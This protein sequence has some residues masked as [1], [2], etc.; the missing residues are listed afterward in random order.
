MARLWLKVK[1]KLLKVKIKIVFDKKSRSKETR[2]AINQNSWL[3]ID[4][5]RVKAKQQDKYLRDILN[6]GGLKQ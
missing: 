5:N 3:S 4:G 1:I 2:E 6:E